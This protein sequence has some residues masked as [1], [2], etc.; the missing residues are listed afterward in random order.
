MRRFIPRYKI[1]T[2]LLLLAIFACVLAIGDR[3]RRIHLAAKLIDA[4]GGDVWLG[5]TLYSGD[6]LGI[7]PRTR[8]QL[9]FDRTKIV[10]KLLCGGKTTLWICSIPDERERSV[11][12]I[13]ILRPEAITFEVL[14]DTDRTWLLNQFSDLEIVSVGTP[15]DDKN[16]P[17]HGVVNKLQNIHETTESVTPKEFIRSMEMAERLLAEQPELSYRL[18][19][20]KTLIGYPEHG[21]MG[22][23][24]DRETGRIIYLPWPK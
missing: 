11:R 5:D 9:I 2:I 8:S 1:R 6:G 18:K 23:L 20:Y 19:R 12:A 24:L 21:E 13:E 22:R 3:A 16:H 7:Q 4:N 15:D 10:A 14:G 17:S